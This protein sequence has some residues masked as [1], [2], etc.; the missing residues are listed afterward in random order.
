MQSD[1][2]V[3]QRQAEGRRIQMQYKSNTNI[4]AT[5][6]DFHPRGGRELFRK[7]RGEFEIKKRRKR[8]YE[9]H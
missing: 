7:L 1:G 5:G 4:A 9:Q 6:A 3:S 8:N 2:R